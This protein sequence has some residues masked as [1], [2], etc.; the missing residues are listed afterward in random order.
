MRGEAHGCCNSSRPTGSFR[1][2]NPGEGKT[3][4]IK[5]NFGLENGEGFK[6]YEACLERKKVL[7]QELKMPALFTY[8]ND[9]RNFWP[10]RILGE[11]MKIERNRFKELLNRT[12][13]HERK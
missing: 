2:S 10:R 6:E 3:I 12:K 4:L 5:A 9:F 1:Y 8:P 13:R 7:Y 11:M